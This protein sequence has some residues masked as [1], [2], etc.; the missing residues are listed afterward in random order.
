MTLSDSLGRV[1]KKWKAC[2]VLLS[3]LLAFTCLFAATI[4]VFSPCGLVPDMCGAC[5]EERSKNAER[6][7]GPSFLIIRTVLFGYYLLYFFKMTSTLFLNDLRKSNKQDPPNEQKRPPMLVGTYLFEETYLP[8]C[9]CL[10]NKRN[11]RLCRSESDLGITVI[12]E[13]PAWHPMSP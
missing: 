5:S 3:V 10:L 6:G 4:F 2:S 11:V 9:S 1:F 13:G 12:P 8:H 7:P